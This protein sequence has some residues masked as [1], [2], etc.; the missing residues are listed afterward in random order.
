[1]ARTARADDQVP[2]PLPEELREAIL[3]WYATRGR[4]LPFRDTA[5]PYAILVSEAMAQQT[6]AARA[7][8]AWTR[9]MAT[10]P[11]VHAL[12]DA[13]PADVL[14]AWQGLGYNRRAINLQRA[15]RIIV[16]EHDGVVPSDLGALEALPGVGP[17]TAR[18]V[19]CRS[20]AM[21]NS[22]PRPAPAR[23]MC[24]TS[25]ASR[26]QGGCSVRRR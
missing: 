3:G 9:F 4:T 23:C 21:S 2:A 22:P 11:T 10:F 17:Y 19:A 25:R 8:E 5:D 16:E 18:A 24:V 7:G 12:A 14:R 15:A 20:A 1:M 6:Q 13:T 26:I